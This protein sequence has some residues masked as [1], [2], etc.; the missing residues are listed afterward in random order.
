VIGIVLVGRGAFPAA[1]LGAWERVDG[2][3]DRARA[4]PLGEEPAAEQRAALLRAV[5]EADAG[6]GVLVLA[7][8]LAE[9]GP[10]VRS[11][12]EEAAIALVG[13]ANLPMLAEIAGRRSG[14]AL[15]ELAAYARDGGR[16]GIALSVPG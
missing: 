7:D 8:S 1:L 13:G 14:A 5:F 15:G 4:V 16:R 10:L 11:I 9:S 2:P 12:M 6:E 3:Q